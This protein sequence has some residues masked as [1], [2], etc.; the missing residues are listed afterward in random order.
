MSLSVTLAN[1]SAGVAAGGG[2][3]S[4]SSENVAGAQTDGFVRRDPRVFFDGVAVRVRSDRADLDPFL[5]RDL[6][7]AVADGAASDVRA[8][9]LE[10][11]AAVT[12]EASG[13]F[14]VSASLAALESAF[15]SLE[16]SPAS[17]AAQRAVL[18]AANDVAGSFSAAQDALD[19]ARARTQSDLEADVALANQALARV[20]A[21]NGEI[22]TADATGRDAN[23]LRDDRDAALDQLAALLPIATHERGDGAVVVTIKGGPTLLDSTMRPLVFDAAVI[24]AGAPPGYPTYPSI[25]VD[26]PNA[27]ATATDLSGLQAGRIGGALV[28]RDQ[29]LIQAQRE[30][31]ALAQ[32]VIVAFQAADASL[33]AGQPGLFVNG[34]GVAVDP[35]VTEPLGLAGRIAVNDAVDPDAGGALRRLRDGVG[36]AAAGPTQDATQI[37]AF[38]GAFSDPTP[39]PPEGGLAV[40]S[41]LSDYAA[42]VGGSRN[43]ARATLNGDADAQAAVAATLAAERSAQG[44]VD[45]DVEAQRLLELEQ[46]YSANAQ[47]LETVQTL[48]DQLLAVVRA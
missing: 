35:A 33:A 15:V 48:L 4:A 46:Y 43:T 26:D 45:L 27:P 25:R 37:R 18:E 47:V 41:S 36:A 20:E 8:A 12:G 17:S 31:D 10:D 40:A 22:V 39:F 21:L 6:R 2:I 32:G 29:D 28:A 14:S 24:P 42:S 7:E 9:R 1:A 5:L 38:I 16:A 23:A 13:V 44:D 3:A 11:L 30:L 34:T 19:D